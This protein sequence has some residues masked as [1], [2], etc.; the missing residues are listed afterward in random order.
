MR[1][2]DYRERWDQGHQMS[3]RE[4]NLNGLIV[5]SL[6]ALWWN[7]RGPGSDNSVSTY[8]LD[9]NNKRVALEIYSADR[10]SGTV[11][12]FMK[13][14]EMEGGQFLGPWKGCTVID[15]RTWSCADEG[16]QSVDGKVTGSTFESDRRVHTVS[17]LRYWFAST[18]EKAGDA[19]K[20]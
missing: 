9:A 16:R 10:S 5:L 7:T 15:Y 6:A 4:Q 11:T 17:A 18:P 14:P 12:Y 3:V 13:D 1:C 19:Q 8:W 2:D 20:Q